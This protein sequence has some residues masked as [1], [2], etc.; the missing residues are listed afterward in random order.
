MR[1][2][3]MRYK[4]YT[5]PHN[6]ETYTVEYRRQVAAHKVPLGGWCLQDLGRTH[7]ILRGEGTFA[8]EGASEEFQALAAVFPEASTA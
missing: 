8:G 5:W 7:R 1:L 3:P 6:P 4:D 2:K